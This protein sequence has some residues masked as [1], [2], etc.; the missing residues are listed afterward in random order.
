MTQVI[1][2]FDEYRQAWKKSVD[3]P[4][5]YWAEQA[6]TFVWQKKW[7]KVLEW[8]FQDPDVKWFINGK[9]NVTENALDRHLAER[10]DKVAILWEP[11]DPNGEVQKYTYRDLYHEVCKT[12]NALKSR[13]IEKGDRVCFYMPMVPELAIGILACARI[14][15]IHSVVF[16]GF[17][18]QAL[19]DR[20][21]DATCKMVIC[22]DFNQRGVKAWANVHNWCGIG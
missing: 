20:I 22:S 10:G 17:S 6:E 11:N 4:E 8:N 19:A 18:A 2:S 21:K 16:A 5:G 14:G 7:D 1:K 3:D 9:L 15:A 12:A 13:G